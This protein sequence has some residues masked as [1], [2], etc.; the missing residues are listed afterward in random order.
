MVTDMK[1]KKMNTYRK[2][3]TI[4][5]ILYILGTVFGILSVIFTQP[6][7]NAQDYFVVVTSNENRVIIGAIFIINDGCG[8][9]DGSSC[10]ISN[11]K[12]GQ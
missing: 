9:G 5:G 8:A 7:A 3:A 10:A 1:E 11:P 4:V 2:N 6:V 12:K